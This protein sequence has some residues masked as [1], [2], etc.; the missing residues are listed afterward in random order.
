MLFAVGGGREP[1][2]EDTSKEAKTWSELRKGV[3]VMRFARLATGALIVSY[4]VPTTIAHGQAAVGWTGP[5]ASPAPQTAK[6]C[7]PAFDP[8]T[9]SPYPACP[10]GRLTDRDREL[11]DIT[12]DAY[13][14]TVNLARREGKL[15]K[16]EFRERMDRVREARSDVGR[17]F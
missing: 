6:R 8:I 14:R 1:D 7:Y 9:L 12:A 4:L 2:C 5:E 16:E 11:I 10:R 3:N 13:K 15:S 17:K